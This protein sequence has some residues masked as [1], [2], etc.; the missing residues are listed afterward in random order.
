[1]VRKFFGT[2]GIRGAANSGNMVPDIAMKLGMAAGSIFTRGDH[3]HRVI[4]G[5]DTRLSCYLFEAALTAGF[6]S[7]GMDVV[8][9]GPMPTP[10]VAM[11]TKSLRA[12][13]GVMISASHN[14]YYDNGIK[15]FGPNGFKLYDDVELEIEQRMQSA[16][17]HKFL[18]H[19]DMLGRATRLDDAPGRYIEFVKNTFPKGKNL[20]GLKII[21]DCANGAAYNIGGNIF[22]ELGADVIELGITPNGLNINDNCGSSYPQNLAKEVVRQKADFGI[23]LDGDADRLVVVDELGNLID[24]DQIMAAIAGYYKQHNL[25]SNDHIIAT[26][27]SNL[28]L[29][30]YLNSIKLNLTR[31]KVGDRYVTEAMRKLNSNVG[32]EQSGHIILSDYATTGDGLIAALQLLAVMIQ[33]QQPASVAFKLF[34]PL[35]QILHN[36]NFKNINC[37]EDVNVIKA[38]KSGEEKLINTGRLLI[39][40]SGTEQLIRI[41]AEGADEL[42]LKQIIADISYEID[43][44]N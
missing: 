22:K 15:L 1:M 10:A 14:P 40:K 21:I 42:L 13:I 32:G 34:T 18:S 25:L 12:D 19:G 6:I 35:P 33:N 8:V 3:R 31:T 28:G 4:I 36:I 27:M 17:L 11:L 23:A 24:G 16:D 38:I 43:L 9:V 30:K 20:E 29:E 41:M 26:V 44:L 5:K 37:L 2:D 7:V 39:R